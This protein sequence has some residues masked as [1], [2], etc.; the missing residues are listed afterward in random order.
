MVDYMKIDSNGLQVLTLDGIVKSKITPEIG[1]YWTR[2]FGY[3]QSCFY[4]G[5]CTQP[6]KMHGCSWKIYEKLILSRMK[7]ISEAALLYDILKNSEGVV[8]VES[9]FNFCSASW[10]NSKNSD[11]LQISLNGFASVAAFILDNRPLL[12]KATPPIIPVNPL[13]NGAQ[14]LASRFEEMVKSGKQLDTLKVE[15]EAINAKLSN[16]IDETGIDEFRERIEGVEVDPAFS[17][18]NRDLLIKVLKTAGL[19]LADY[20]TNDVFIKEKKYYMETNGNIRS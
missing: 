7:S 18:Q 13:I 3:C 14:T 19:E 20:I 4:K 2:T 17:K 11:T 16:Y 6:H 8:P 15:Q 1:D 9:L 12:Y 5:G 10:E